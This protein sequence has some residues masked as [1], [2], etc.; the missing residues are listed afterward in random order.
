MIPG[1]YKRI[2]DHFEALLHKATAERPLYVFLD[3]VDQ[4]SPDDG[5]SGMSWLPV[6]L[7]AHVKIVLSTSSEVHYRCYPVLQS[8]L[9][10][11]QENF[12][13][14]VT[15]H[16]SGGYGSHDKP[17]T[18]NIVVTTDDTSSYMILLLEYLLYFFSILYRLHLSLPLSAETFSSIVSPARKGS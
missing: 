5:A 16:C 12:I 8:L 11:Y 13:E 10:K 4:L 9:Y 18:H 1:N 15:L 14:V 7:P 2:A 6:S 17:H 3:A